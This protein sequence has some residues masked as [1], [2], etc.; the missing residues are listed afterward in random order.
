MN[1][2]LKESAEHATESLDDFF[3]LQV[4]LELSS[5][6]AEYVR[7]IPYGEIVRFLTGYSQPIE[8]LGCAPVFVEVEQVASESLEFRG[9]LLYTLLFDL[10]SKSVSDVIDYIL[11]PAMNIEPNGARIVEDI[12]LACSSF[13]RMQDISPGGTLGLLAAILQERGV[14]LEGGEEAVGV[15]NQM[16]HQYWEASVNGKVT[17]AAQMCEWMEGTFKPSAGWMARQW[18]SGKSRAVF[19]RW[20][21]GELRHQFLSMVNFVAF[22]VF[23]LVKRYLL[24]DPQELASI[25]EAERFLAKALLAQFREHFVNGMQDL[26]NADSPS[27]EAVINW[28]R[29]LHRGLLGSKGTKPDQRVLE[30]ISRLRESMAEYEKTPNS[31][32]REGQIRYALFIANRL[33]SPVP[34]LVLEWLALSLYSLHGV[35]VKAKSD[36]ISRRLGKEVHL[37]RSVVIQRALRGLEYSETLAY[38]CKK[39]YRDHLAHSCRVALYGL[40]LLDQ[41]AFQDAQP[42]EVDPDPDLRSACWLYISLLHDC[43]YVLEHLD[44]LFG[45]VTHLADTPTIGSFDSDLRHARGQLIYALSLAMRK[46]VYLE[47]KI[48]VKSVAH[49]F[50]SYDNALRLLGHEVQ[51][52]VLRVPIRAIALHHSYEHVP[53]NPLKYEFWL[54]L[55][56]EFQEWGRAVAVPPDVAQFVQSLLATG[57]AT[58]Q[59]AEMRGT[60]E[61]QEEFINIS[62][63]KE[64]STGV[65][66]FVLEVALNLPGFTDVFART[67]FN[68]LYFI[69]NKLCVLNKLGRDENTKFLGYVRLVVDICCHFNNDDQVDNWLRYFATLSGILEREI[70]YLVEQL[71]IATRE[72]LLGTQHTDTLQIKRELSGGLLILCSGLEKAVQSTRDVPGVY[73]IC[74][75]KVEALPEPGKGF[76]R[77]IEFPKGYNPT[78]EPYW[79]SLERVAEQMARKVN[80]VEVT[81]VDILT[82]SMQLGLVSERIVDLHESALGS[83]IGRHLSREIMEKY[84]RA[85]WGS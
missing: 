19:L 12:R 24:T 30:A 43:G 31:V 49:P 15:G 11:S 45:L 20:L 35:N 14:K 61:I 6:L 72:M 56:D 53:I 82:K 23:T 41:C 52:S 33:N 63:R 7:D 65:D 74:R 46:D 80:G 83:L 38:A 81:D 22:L 5:T 85:P 27:Y 54:A 58:T 18:Q 3:H 17:L 64:S 10:V 79:I 66:K 55:L 21:R 8:G 68:P 69:W 9:P 36:E 75:L 39:R 59:L 26:L 44:Y 84:G 29:F 62:S 47:N 71:R 78:G 42:G 1:V 73:R 60:T 50:V 57:V 37:P 28:M 2:A 51:Q 40:D 76:M 13:R 32:G 25:Q 4:L 70:Q 34:S 48:Q 16:M 77:T 67:L